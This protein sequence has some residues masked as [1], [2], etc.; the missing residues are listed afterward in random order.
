M[1]KHNGNKKDRRHNKG[2]NSHTK[3]PCPSSTIYVCQSRS[4]RRYGADAA[5]V[6]L[7]ELV[8]LLPAPGAANEDEEE[9]ESRSGACRMNNVKVSTRGCMG[10]CRKGPAVGVVTTHISSNSN[11][12][13]SHNKKNNNR[14]R[15]NN[16][17]YSEQQVHVKVNTLEKSA[18]VVQSATGLSKLPYSLNKLPKEVKYR[19]GKLR[20][21]KHSQSINQDNLGDSTLVTNCHWN[22]TLCS[23]LLAAK[24]GQS[25]PQQEKDYKLLVNEIKAILSKAGYPAVS[26]NDLIRL[27]KLNGRSSKRHCLLQSKCNFPQ[28]SPW[29]LVLLF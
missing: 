21:A 2:K 27:K 9:E 24:Q 15:R 19:L 5:L 3:A 23:L 20:Y 6:E 1:P 8:A 28:N 29:L 7:E 10:Y 4:C 11:G 17:H 13:G 26:P 18:A 16:Y 22:K 25:H 14:R 12:S